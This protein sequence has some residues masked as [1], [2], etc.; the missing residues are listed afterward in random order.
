MQLANLC[1]IVVVPRE[2]FGLTYYCLDR[3]YAST[4]Q[5]LRIVVVEGCAPPHVRAWLARES[6]ARGF[7]W[8]SREKFLTPNQARNI[9]LQAVTTPYA[10]FLDSDAIVEPGC[11][12]A[13]L[14]CAPETGAAVVGPLYLEGKPE[15]R[16]IHMAAG[17]AHLDELNGQRHLTVEHRYEFMKLADIPEPLE[18]CECEV[19]EFHCMLIRRD[20][21]L[22]MRGFDER[23]CGMF[24]EPDFCMFARGMGEHVF[25]EPR[26]VV[27]YPRGLAFELTDRPYCLWRWSAQHV[28]ESREHFEHKWH[29]AANDAQMQRYVAW[30][31]AVRDQATRMFEYIEARQQ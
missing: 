20:L 26:A 25:F 6:K 30:T 24:E 23:I 10:V 8:I 31:D 4:T 14:Q 29:L 1:T 13:L 28:T 18:R 17:N 5:A 16:V 15:D 11:L 19:M 12:E 7:I 2:R 27:T 22:R 3:V 9:G 21:L